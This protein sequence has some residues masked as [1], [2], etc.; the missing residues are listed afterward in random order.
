MSSTY[1]DKLTDAMEAAY[2]LMDG[3]GELTPEAEEKVELAKANLLTAIA[4]ELAAE[5]G[6]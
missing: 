3:W 2:D 6:K 5:V 1:Y 4:L